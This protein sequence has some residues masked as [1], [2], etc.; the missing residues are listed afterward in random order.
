[1]DNFGVLG[2]RPTHPELLDYLAG[3]F[4]EQGW[5][6]KSLIR[7]IVLSS[8]YQM[9]SRSDPQSDAADPRNLLLHHKPVRR[10]EGEAIR[11]AI[12]AVSG[13]LDRTM[14]GPSVEVYLTPFLEG[15]GRPAASGPLDGAGR[16][17]IYLRIRR[18]F[19]HP[20][21]AAFDA[22]TPFTTIGRR[23]VSNVPAQALA[24]MNNPFVTEQAKLWGEQVVGNRDATVA[25][26]VTAMYET[27]FA[28]LPNPNELAD[29]VAFIEQQAARRGCEPDDARVWSDLGHVLFNVKE[30]VFVE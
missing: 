30:F 29:A 23:S 28:R 8:T 25:E 15:R 6:I 4:V 24:L 12:L 1:V 14:F 9:S 21:L 20:M 13:R 5:S 18:N 22:P 11:D 27:A 17:S 10:L 16:R 2:E 7:E 26:R 3:R 19:P